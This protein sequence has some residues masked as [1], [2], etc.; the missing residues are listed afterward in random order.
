[1][2][3]EERSLK[4]KRP[5]R[6]HVRPWLVTM[7]TVHVC[8]R[9]AGYPGF[10][11]QRGPSL[12][13]PARAMAHAC[14]VAA[15]VPDNR[16]GSERAPILS[17]CAHALDPCAS[18]ASMP[19]YRRGFYGMQAAA[20]PYACPCARAY[21]HGASCWGAPVAGGWPDSRRQ[22]G[23]GAGAHPARTR[24]SAPHRAHAT[25]ARACGGPPAALR[26]SVRTLL[27]RFY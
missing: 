9:S 5:R 7:H 20:P 10:F 6:K 3:Q 11:E 21:V 23:L 25:D 18:N 13:D 1:M 14:Q 17:P 12:V 8:Y 15:V 27:W 16:G 19:H 24:R 26:R 22:G 2:A 4:S